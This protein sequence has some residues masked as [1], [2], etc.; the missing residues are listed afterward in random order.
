MKKVKIEKLG[1][2]TV[3]CDYLEYLNKINSEVYYS[4]SYRTNLKPFVG[5]V[6]GIGKYNY[7]IPVTSAKQKHRKW[8]NISDEHFLIYQT[9]PKNENF[10][11]NIYKNISGEEKMQILSVLDIKKMI[12]VPNGCYEKIVF[13]KIRDRKYRSL[14]KKEYEF[15]LS[16]IDKVLMKVE[17]IYKHQKETGIIRRAYCNFKQLESAMDKWKTKK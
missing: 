9:V 14:L 17:K 8:K 13:N 11:K 3:N 1:F 10:S 6:V 15:C 5:I 16:V 12:P 2:Y 7:F 4:P